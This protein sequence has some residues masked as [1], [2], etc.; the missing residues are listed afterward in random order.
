MIFYFEVGKA[1]RI[2][3][4]AAFLRRMAGMEDSSRSRADILRTECEDV[5]D[6]IWQDVEEKI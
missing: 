5:E 2:E 4:D 3:R 6:R 1:L